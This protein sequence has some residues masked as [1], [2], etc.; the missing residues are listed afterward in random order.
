MENA[1][2]FTR[3]PALP[4][5]SSARGQRCLALPQRF[6]SDFLLL[7]PSWGFSCQPHWDGNTVP[8][9]LPGERRSC[10]TTMV[11]FK[12]TH[13][14]LM[15]SLPKAISF[16]AALPQY[17]P[18]CTP[19]FHFNRSKMKTAQH[20][21]DYCWNRTQKCKGGKALKHHHWEAEGTEAEL[22][23]HSA[24]RSRYTCT[25]NIHSCYI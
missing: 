2:C 13:M 10:L 11:N 23:R 25:L 6:A 20:P 21:G 7:E 24:A 17:W 1:P 8:G 16:L 3:S 5:R 4:A 22:Q 19:C 14:G 12:V 9:S 15:T 18:R